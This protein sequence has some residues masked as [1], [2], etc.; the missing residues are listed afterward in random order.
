MNWKIIRVM[1]IVGALVFGFMK[2]GIGQTVYNTGFEDVADWTQ[3]RPAK[4]LTGYGWPI[5]WS[6]YNSGNPTYPPPKK[7]DGTFLFDM[8]RAGATL[9]DPPNVTPMVE[10]KNGIGRNKGRGLNYNVEV[11]GTN[12]TWTGGEPAGIWLGQDGFQDVYVRFYLKYPPEWKWTNDSNPIS[13]RSAQQKIMKIARYN[14]TLNDGGNPALYVA[15]TGGGKNH[16]VWIPDWYQY[17]SVSPS[18]SK[19]LNSERLSP[20]YTANDTQSDA[21]SQSPSYYPSGND[22]LWPTDSD[23]HCYEFRAKM[24]SAPGVTDGISEIWMDG[25]R[26]WSKRNI[27][28]VQT[29]GSVVQGWNSITILDNATIPAYPLVSQVTY[30]LYLDDVVVSTHYSG[31]PPKP[32]TVVAQVVADKTAK[33]TWSAG[34]NGATNLID[35]YRVYYGTDVSALTSSV[36]VSNA[37]EVVI[38]NLENIAKYYFAVTAFNKQAYD[39]NEN[40]S[41]KSS[42][43]AIVPAAPKNLTGTVTNP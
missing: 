23:W 40:E 9:F 36:V 33:V 11:S 42:T 37:T 1:V 32:N 29:G 35:G 30:Q 10:I 38:P 24:N 27:A 7:N 43:V 5:T 21:F 34:T 18:Y 28:W 17:I 20:N 4:N 41:L 16:P 14:G 39:A 22:F 25:V 26:R 15:P 6:G 8:F 31:P 12:G 2:V 3:T 19:F 13:N